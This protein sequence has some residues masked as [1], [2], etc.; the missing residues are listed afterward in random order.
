VAIESAVAPRVGRSAS[1]CDFEFLHQVETLRPQ[2]VV[3]FGAGGGKNA[4]LIRRLLGRDCRLI[5]VEGFEPTITYLRSQSGLYDEVDHALLQEWVLAGSEHYDLAVFGDVLEHLPPRAV[6][7]VL[8]RALRRFKHV[9]IVVP[10]HDLFQDDKDGNTLEIHRTYMTRSFF[11]RYQPLEQHI[12][13]SSDYTIMNVLLTPKERQ[14]LLKRTARA[15]FHGAMLALQPFGLARVA[16]ELLKA[17]GRPLKH[18]I[19]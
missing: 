11:D 2:S 10:L 6:H 15:G 13:S 4:Q 1:L 17:V 18:L 3:D 19:R 16:V 9:I 14:S 8:E 12:V 7:A 5:A